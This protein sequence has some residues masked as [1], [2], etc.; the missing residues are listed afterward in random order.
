MFKHHANYFT[1]QCHKCMSTTNPQPIQ[2][3][4]NLE[5]ENEQVVVEKIFTLRNILCESIEVNYNIYTRYSYTPHKNLITNVP[6]L[7]TI[8][9]THSFTTIKPINTFNSIHLTFDRQILPSS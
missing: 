8:L 2:Q 7:H 3:T 1:I 9:P 5:E 4:N 6:Q